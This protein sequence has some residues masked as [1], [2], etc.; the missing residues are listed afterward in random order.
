MKWIT[1]T[2]KQVSI[3]DLTDDHL[4]NII[5]MLDRSQVF[6]PPYIF[7]NPFDPDSMAHYYAEQAIDNEIIGEPEEHPL[8]EDLSAE[9]FKRNLSHRVYD[10]NRT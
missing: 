10:G 2:G 4:V 9:L 6:E 8:Y 3:D 1:A 5:K 7:A